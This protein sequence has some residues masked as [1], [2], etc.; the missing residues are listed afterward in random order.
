M[1]EYFNINSWEIIL[2]LLISWI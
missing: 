2:M 1:K